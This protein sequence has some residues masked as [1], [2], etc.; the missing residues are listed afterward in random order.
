MIV[1]AW[2][3]QIWGHCFFS[4]YNFFLQRC[5]LNQ[6]VKLIIS[7][8][9]WLT[10]NTFVFEC[11]RSNSLYAVWIKERNWN[12]EKSSADDVASSGASFT[13][14]NTQASLRGKTRQH[15][16][17][18]KCGNTRLDSKGWRAN[19]LQST[20]EWQL[21]YQ[22]NIRLRWGVGLYMVI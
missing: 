14:C 7:Y 15:G 8:Y 21:L 12:T 20:D 1:S 3:D 13:R 6:T 18:C 17:D 9:L 2:P 16:G 19:Q 11:Y 4:H 22:H 5:R 10:L